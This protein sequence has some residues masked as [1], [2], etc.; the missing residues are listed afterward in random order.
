[1]TDASIPQSL[2]IDGPVFVIGEP[3][4]ELSSISGDQAQLG[5][6]GDTF[7][8]SVYLKRA[9][10]DVQYVT[11]LGDDTLSKRV[12]NALHQEGVG[13]DFIEIVP[14]QPVGLYA[15]DVDE[16]GERS[17]T[18]WRSAS[19]FRSWFDTKGAYKTLA[20]MEEAA[21][22]Y[23]S[24][25]TLSVFTDANR[26]RLADL[27]KR[28]R[29]NGGHVAFDT[30]YRP[31]G[32]STSEAARDAVN[33]LMPFVT[34]ALPTFEDEANL[35]GSP[36]PEECVS[37]W[38]TA[39]ASE[40]CVKSGPEGA[41]LSVGG[42]VT[43]KTALKPKDTTGAGDSFNGAYLAARLLGNAPME[44]ASQANDL[45]GRVIMISGAILPNT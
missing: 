10:V 7:N 24:G 45:A 1:M 18:Y 35:F 8:T 39:G 21:L 34:L 19:A 4:I 27:S 6:G 32:W 37:R 36:S 42:W 26:A 28:V 14:G 11:T 23:L 2:N 5:V 38:Q 20:A 15:I 31:A 22:L 13:T 41:L 16:F 29:R 9:G 12:L 44:A 30:N 3:M 43:P 25:I 17:F 33:Q 40:V